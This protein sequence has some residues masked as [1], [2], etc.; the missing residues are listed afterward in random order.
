VEQTW[1]GRARSRPGRETWSEWTSGRRSAGC[2]SS[3]ACRLR[4]STAGR[5]P[6]ADDSAGA[7]VERAAALP[8]VGA[9]LD[10]RSVQRG[11]AVVVLRGLPER[12]VSKVAREAARARR[13]GPWRL[14]GQGSACA[15]TPP[16]SS[17]SSTGVSRGCARS[18][19]GCLCGCMG[20]ARR[21]QFARLAPMPGWRRRV[22]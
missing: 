20:S 6:S 19:R 7:A 18:R 13:R 17:G 2:S 1:L 12:G 5:S 14:V 21:T 4:R 10:A 15:A 8:S 11:W 3:R 22:H 16:I 9:A